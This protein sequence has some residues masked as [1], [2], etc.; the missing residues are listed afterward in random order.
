L[1]VKIDVMLRFLLWFH[2]FIFIYS[3]V[4]KRWGGGL[5]V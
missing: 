3:W 2:L 5:H 4:K 1:A